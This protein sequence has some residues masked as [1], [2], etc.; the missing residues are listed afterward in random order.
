MSGRAPATNTV[1][2]CKPLNESLYSSTQ[3]ETRAEFAERSVAKLEKTIDDLEGMNLFHLIFKQRQSLFSQNVRV[4]LLQCNCDSTPLF[5][6]FWQSQ[7][8]TKYFFFV[9]IGSVG[10]F[11]WSAVLKTNLCAVSCLPGRKKQSIHRGRRDIHVG[12]N[13]SHHNAVWHS[14]TLSVQGQLVS[15]LQGHGTCE[16]V[17]LWL[18]RNLTQHQQLL[19][20]PFLFLFPSFSYLCLPFWLLFSDSLFFLFVFPFFKKKLQI[21]H[22]H[23]IIITTQ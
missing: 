18:L 2:F 23:F 4:C 9:N 15:V 16:A 14:G 5:P 1:M 19:H 10:L 8:R 11:I 6:N 22:C 3:A 17:S 20:A 13:I 7:K 21:L 12:R